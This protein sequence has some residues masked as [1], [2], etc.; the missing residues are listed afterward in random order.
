MDAPKPRPKGNPAWK[1][2]VSGNPKG[3]GKNGEG[4][5][6]LLDTYMAKKAKNEGCDHWLEHVV[7][8]A[9]NDPKLMAAVLKKLIPD[10]TE[11]SGKFSADLSGKI[12]VEFVHAEKEPDAD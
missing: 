2:G 3:R 9:W 7:D 11:L 1:K 6:A 4:L 5:S 12:I 10:K 8:M